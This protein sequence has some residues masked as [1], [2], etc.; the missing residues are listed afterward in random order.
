MIVV[1]KS[2][3]QLCNR[4]FLYSYLIAAARHYG[5][6]LANPCFAEYAHFFPSTALDLWCR[7]PVEQS[8]SPP[9]SIGRRKRLAKSLYLGSRALSTCGL[10]R[11][12]FSI[13]RLRGVNTECDL[14]GEEFSELV[15]RDRHLLVDGWLFLSDD[16]LQ[17]HASAVRDHFR[18]PDLQQQRV[19][20][21]MSNVR[22]RADVVVGVH[23]RHGDYATY[24]DGKYFY[25]VSEYATAMRRVAE[26]LA[27]QRV[28]FMVCS[29]AK[30][31]PDVFD[32]LNVVYGPGDVIEDLYSLAQ[33]DLLMGP[34]STFTRWAAFYGNVPLSVMETADQEIDTAPRL[35]WPAA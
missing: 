3:G 20:K 24:L 12:P 15:R 19:D 7:Y 26:K 5:V 31:D 6:S 21:H 16:L 14:A 4:L 28:T 25:E 11:F 18:I 10:T 1:T 29:N 27:P 32:G 23:I 33:T 30:I 8:D 22:Q 35:I 9:P 2:Y 34:P 17:Q 13:I